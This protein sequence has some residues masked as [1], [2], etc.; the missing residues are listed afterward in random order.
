MRNPKKNRKRFLSLCAAILF[1][2]CIPGS[3]AE[4]ANET[5]KQISVNISDKAELVKLL[6]IPEI[7]ECGPN[8]NFEQGYV[9]LSVNEYE[10]QQIVNAGFSYSVEI[11]DLEK[12][13]SEQMAGL[14]MGGFRTF[15]EIVAK[16]DSINSD[17]PSI[18]KLDSIGSS[19]E[20]NTIWAMKISDNVYE[21]EE[22]EPE[23]LFTGITHAREPI[24][25]EICVDFADWLCTNYGDDPEATAMVNERQIWFIPVINP[26][27]YLYNEDT[28]P[29]GGGM[30]RKNRRDNGG[31]VYGVDNNRNY[32]YNW[33]YDN[34][35][36]SP[37]P[38]SN[39]YRGPYA[40]SEPENQAVMW[41][42]EQHNFQTA[43]HYHSGA[44]ALLHAWGYD[45]VFTPEQYFY[46]ALADSM[47]SFTGYEVGTTWQVMYQSNGNAYDYS[48]GEQDTKNKIFGFV[49]EAGPFWPS[50][51]QIPELVELHRNYNIAL[52]QL[53][54]NIFRA[55]IPI[56]PVINEM[57]TDPDGN[58]TVTWDM[59]AADT[60]PDFYELQEVFNPT[61]TTDGAE[62]GQDNWVLEGFSVSTTHHSGS[63][64]YYS[65]LGDNYHS[66][67]TLVS[68]VE[69]TEPTD[70]TF[71]INYDI[72]FAY[73]YGYLEV[74]TDGYNYDSLDT[75][76]G[77]SGGWVSRS[78]SLDPYIGEQIYI[79]YRYE[80]D[81]YV[82][83]PGFYID[84]INPVM[85]F[86]STV[87]IADNITEESYDIT[88]KDDGTYYYRVRAQN[89]Q[90]WGIFGNIE[91]ITVTGAG[92]LLEVGFIPVN[93]PIEVPQGGS[94]RFHAGVINYGETPAYI[95]CWVGLRLP[96][97]SYYSP[98]AVLND[99]LAPAEDTLIFMNLRQNI[100]GYAPLGDYTYIGYIG[101]RPSTIYDSTYFD[102]TVI[103][104][105]LPE[106]SD[107]GWILEGW[108]N[109]EI[110]TQTVLYDNYP[111]PFNAETNITFEVPGNTGVLL[112]VYNLIGQKV[113][114]LIDANLNAG[115]HTVSW[116]ASNAS[117]GVYF[118]KLSAG[119][120]IV[121]KRMTL[122]K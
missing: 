69:I 24:S 59:L 74:S 25:G 39:T 97:L 87:T 49:A 91:D 84:N 12:Y 112:E 50:Q 18:T 22:D 6:S 79:R 15:S 66:T 33:G 76:T 51:Y 55:I 37:D 80:T 26:D 77:S 93:P 94:F 47:A 62:D 60:L 102:F 100:P 21:E 85:V 64:S 52:T 45:H 31:G 107:N 118:Y 57:T 78:Y 119:D 75:Y 58:F 81:Q 14:T 8:V 9:E 67:M 88:G 116:N 48:Y 10:I 71:N 104:S 101:D 11:D 42:C 44:E 3:Y 5:Y 43:I 17:Y 73:D 89:I 72:E 61:I 19:H 68:P 23:V 28:N 117:S 108:G 111:N 114:K 53:A 105:D 103:P 1:F 46:R 29:N 2:T 13:Y 40:G 70:L 106:N 120:N 82:T 122:L 95:D 56:A 54:D 36:S 27:G 110:P 92:P 115:R 113:A 65:G 38:G 35:G 16:L 90:G 83:D 34:Y 41:L 99:V 7:S 4:G 20:G 96:D 109:R 86:D 98:L 32:T 63:Y 121:T 30:W